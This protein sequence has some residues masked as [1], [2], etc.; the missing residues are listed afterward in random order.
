MAKRLIDSKSRLILAF[1]A[2]FPIGLI[3][4]GTVLLLVQRKLTLPNFINNQASNYYSTCDGF[5]K[6]RLGKLKLQKNIQFQK[7]IRAE[8]TNHYTNIYNYESNPFSSNQYLTLTFT[9]EP[10]SIQLIDDELAQEIVASD[11]LAKCT[12][13]AKVT[14]AINSSDDIVTWFRMNNPTSTEV[15]VQK[16]ECQSE[17]KKKVSDL[18]WGQY[19]CPK[20]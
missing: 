15:N 2:L 14:F 13:V 17:A 20:S 5:I 7:A 19:L 8:M 16:G 6:S 3:F 4:F 11:V 10:N 18:L 9:N 1:L 12:Q